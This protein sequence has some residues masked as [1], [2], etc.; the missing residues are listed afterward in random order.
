MV[1]KKEGELVGHLAFPFTSEGIWTNHF[2][3]V[4]QLFT[5]KI[6]IKIISLPSTLYIK[7][8]FKLVSLYDLQFSP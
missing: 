7:E 1:K 2:I 3:S 5:C 6:E 4:P 8:Y